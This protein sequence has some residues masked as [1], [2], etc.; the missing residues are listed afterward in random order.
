[1]RAEKKQMM[2]KHDRYERRV[3]A[4]LGLASTLTSIVAGVLLTP[5]MLK[6]LDQSQFGL[7][8]LIGAFIGYLSLMDFGISGTLTRYIAK[9]RVE[10]DKIRQ[11]NLFSMCLIIYFVLGVILLGIGYCIYENLGRMFAHSLTSEELPQARM[12]FAIVLVSEIGRA[13]V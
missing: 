7:Y 5:I 9:Y 8:Q 11:D 3:G 1:L 2:S 13:H 6:Y 10:G 4:A 12:M